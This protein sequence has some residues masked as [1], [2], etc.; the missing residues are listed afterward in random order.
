MIEAVRKTVHRGLRRRGG[1]SGLHGR[2]AELVADRAPPIHGN[3]VKEIVLEEREGGGV[4]EVSKRKVRGALGDRHSRG[5]PPNRLVPAWNILGRDPVGTEG[6]VR[7]LP[8][9]DATRVE[10]EHRGWDAI[11]EQAAGEAGLYDT[12]WDYVSAAS[13]GAPTR[14]ADV[15]R[16][17]TAGPSS[18]RS[19]ERREAAGE[20]R[21][22]PPPRARRASTTNPR[23]HALLRAAPP[24]SG[25]GRLE[26]R[27]ANEVVALALA[28]PTSARERHLVCPPSR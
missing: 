25:C 18:E 23:G 16:L 3:D 7:F 8:E 26:R 12:G 10:P 14:K 19:D 4:F 28:V 27:D 6:R 1:I 17:G 15:H 24:T 22:S 9:G 20:Q 5:D 21:V 2:C 13:R 11:A